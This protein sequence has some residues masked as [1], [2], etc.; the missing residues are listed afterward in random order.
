M[1][2]PYSSKK[3]IPE[4]REMFG[5]DSVKAFQKLDWFESQDFWDELFI[6]SKELKKIHLA[7]GEPLLIKQCWKFLRRLIEAGNSKNLILSYNTNLTL[8]PEEAK[9]IWPHFKEVHIIAS[10]DGVGRANEFIR[11]P[12]N[13]EDFEN[14]L[15]IL[16][17]ERAQYNVHYLEI[18][19]TA[20]VYNIKRIPEICD[21][22]ATNFQTVIPVP[23]F[24][25]VYG[26][27]EFD[28]QILPAFYREE[29]A[30]MMEDY[31]ADLL[32]GRNQLPI[33]H[34]DQLT[35]NLKSLIHHLRN[36]DKTEHFHSFKRLNDIF[37]RN[38]GQRTFDF[39]PELERAYNGKT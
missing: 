18:H 35:Q 19:P 13:W 30:L 4:Y 12:S 5:E 28:P 39:I 25:I 38:R 20:Q 17:K 9:E 2:I 10:M 7:G 31:V 6:Y 34:R 27:V 15:K 33:F 3:L 8:L 37:D 11:H 36:G 1:C 14:N 32:A 16:D 24:D 26:P 23:R 22:V 29:A 21:Y